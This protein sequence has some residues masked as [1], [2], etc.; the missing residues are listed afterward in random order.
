MTNGQRGGSCQKLPEEYYYDQ[1][2]PKVRKALQE[3][4]TMWSSRWCYNMVKQHGADWVI[5]KLK[6]ADIDFMK[7]GF[8]MKAFTKNY[9]SSFVAAKV[10]P[11]K[12]N[13]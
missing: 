4:V 9:P 6:L 11:L 8:V 1:L 13:W 3:S 10:K 12:A 2:G 7:K 5:N